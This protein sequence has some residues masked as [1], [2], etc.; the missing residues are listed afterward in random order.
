MSTKPIPPALEPY[1]RLPPEAS[2]IL[3]TGTL[4]CSVNW[5]TCRFIATALSQPA[6]QDGNEN[7]DDTTRPVV[8]ISWLRDLAWWKGEVKRT[9]GLDITRPPSHLTFVPLLS[10]TNTLP[11]TLPLTLTAPLL[12]LDVPLPPSLPTLLPLRAQAHAT[13]LSTAADIPLLSPTTTPLET[14]AAE[15]LIVAAHSA[16]VVMGVR[17]LETGAARDVSG[18]LR[19]TRGG[20]WEGDGE[21]VEEREMLYFVG[22]DGGVRVFG[23]GEQ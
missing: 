14:S 3:L 8:L 22:R 23:R 1:L 15:F 10:P 9:T 19:V 2:L 11:T 5:L 18:A 7:E 4:G 21:E 17:E 12:I 20:G 16:R 6:S 13:I